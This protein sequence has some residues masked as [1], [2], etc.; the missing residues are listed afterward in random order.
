MA[1]SC[2]LTVAS[3]WKLPL[4]QAVGGACI[5]VAEQVV[6]YHVVRCSPVHSVFRPLAHLAFGYG[7]Q[8]EEAGQWLCG[9]ECFLVALLHGENPLVLVV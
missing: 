6:V 4:L 2:R 3:A 1:I 5:V 9:S 7:G 8:G